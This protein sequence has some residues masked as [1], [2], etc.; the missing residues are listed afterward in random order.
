MKFTDKIYTKLGETNVKIVT[1]IANTNTAL[2]TTANSY[3][4]LPIF[5]KIFPTL[6][7]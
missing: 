4:F 7:F 3:T 5:I 6:C 2:E 1:P